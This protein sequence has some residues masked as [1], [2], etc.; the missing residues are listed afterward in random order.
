MNSHRSARQPRLFLL[1]ALSFFYAAPPASAGVNWRSDAAGEI[2]A[3]SLLRDFYGKRTALLGSAEGAT[4]AGRRK[5]EFLSSAVAFFDRVVRKGEMT[6]TSIVK[7]TGAPIEHLP[8]AARVLGAGAEAPPPQVSIRRVETRL[9]PDL[10]GDVWLKQSDAARAALVYFWMGELVE[11]G[12]VP[13]RPMPFY[14][15]ELGERLV[16]NRGL[17]D[18]PLRDLFG[19][20]ICETDPAAVGVCG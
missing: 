1:L 11:M 19:D 7:R 13:G 4:D 15:R 2:T 17:M 18:R 16:R 10:S 12:V 6:E 20:L 14:W 5:L 3:N 8:A 9:S